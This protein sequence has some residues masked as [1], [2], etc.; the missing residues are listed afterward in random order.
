MILYFGLYTQGSGTRCDAGDKNSQP[1][2][3]KNLNPILVSS[4]PEKSFQKKTVIYLLFLSQKQEHLGICKWNI[5]SN[6]I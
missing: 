1:T 2:Q 5:L 3:G 4:I 6:D